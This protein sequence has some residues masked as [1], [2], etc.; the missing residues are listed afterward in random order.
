MKNVIKKAAKAGAN[1]IAENTIKT[2][3]LQGENAM[4]Q[5][6][7]VDKKKLQIKVRIEI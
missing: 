7:V 5:E 2:A 1:D 4:V 3:I 6:A